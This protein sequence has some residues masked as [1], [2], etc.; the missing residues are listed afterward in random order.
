M[1]NTI[2][3]QIGACAAVLRRGGRHR[4]TGGWANATELIDRIKDGIRFVGPV[5]VPGENEMVALAQAGL[6]V[7]GGE[8]KARDYPS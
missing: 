1:A 2:A 4:L 5:F 3:K 8:E 6:R 7:V